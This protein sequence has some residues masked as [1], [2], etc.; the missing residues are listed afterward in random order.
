MKIS[1]SLFFTDILPH[2]RNWYHKIVKNKVFS[3]KSPKEGFFQL[4]AAGMDGVELILPSFFIPKDHEIT[5]VKTFLDSCGL[6]V[7]SVHQ[8]VR[9]LTKTKMQEIVELFHIADVLGAKVIVLHMNT[10]GRQVFDERYVKLVHSLQN[11]YGIR[12]GFENMEKYFGSLHRKHSWHGEKFADLMNEND[13]DITLDTTHLAH[14]DGDII[15]FYKKNKKR[16]I[17][18][19]LSDYK[20]HFLNGT[21]RP[22]R[23]KHLP[24]GEGEL[25]VEAF[26]QLLKKEK[27]E[28]LI[29]MEIHTDLTGMCESAKII[30]DIIKK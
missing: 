19:H 5:E 15:D 2:K 29:T 16:I 14:S 25:P 30:A 3:D 8:V 6:P 10:A 12:V 26:L 7:L 23:Y 11:K 20:P 22:M 4:K 27:Y 18:I 13:F 9:F 21:L 1:A 28:G 17:N 24:L